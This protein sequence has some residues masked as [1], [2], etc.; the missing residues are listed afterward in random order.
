MSL[1]TKRVSYAIA[2]RFPIFNVDVSKEL[3]ESELRQ[4]YGEVKRLESAVAD[5]LGTFASVL[6][7]APPRSQASKENME[8]VLNYAQEKPLLK[9]AD[10]RLDLGISEGAAYAALARLVAEKKLTRFKL[11]GGAYGYSLPKPGD[12]LPV[13]DVE[14]AEAKQV[15]EDIK[16]LNAAEVQARLDSR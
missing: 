2:L 8:K 15:R 13:V 6:A 12:S 5:Q 10:V 3:S 7:A 11:S 16:R 4:F 9:V 1:V 14:G